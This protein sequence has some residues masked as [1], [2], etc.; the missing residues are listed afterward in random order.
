MGTTRF[1]AF[2]PWAGVGQSLVYRWRPGPTPDTCFM[3]VIRMAPNPDSGEIP[4]PAP[5]QVLTLDQSWHEAEAMGQLADVFQQDMDN[6]PKV[7]AGLK[8]KGKRG[9]SFGLYQET[10]MRMHHRMIDGYIELKRS[11]VERLNMTTHPIEFD[12]YYSL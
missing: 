2:A 7:Q 1:P 6:L 10:R 8:S 9:V 5:H 4:D 3:D 12:M 11:E